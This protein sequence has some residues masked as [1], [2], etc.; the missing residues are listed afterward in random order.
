MPMELIIRLDDQGQVSVTG[1]IGDQLRAYG[2]LA[3]AKDVIAD[4]HRAQQ[5][6]LV[7]PTSTLLEQLA[8]GAAGSAHKA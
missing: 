4:Y 7:Q 6:R 2:L 5:A 3:C 1:A 8:R